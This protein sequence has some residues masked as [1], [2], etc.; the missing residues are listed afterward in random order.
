MT[1]IEDQEDRYG[2]SLLIF[3][4]VKSIDE[5]YFWLQQHYDG[6]KFG[7]VF[8]CTKDELQKPDRKVY[9]NWLDELADEVMHYCDYEKTDKHTYKKRGIPR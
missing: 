1:V 4:G 8:D 7:I 6:Y 3:S 2:R 5:V 9:V